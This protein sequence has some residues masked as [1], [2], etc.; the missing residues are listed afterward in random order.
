[1]YQDFERNKQ[2]LNSKLHPDINF[3]LV[4]RDITIGNRKAVF[5]L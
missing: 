5:S 3:D 2:Y 4:S 1:M